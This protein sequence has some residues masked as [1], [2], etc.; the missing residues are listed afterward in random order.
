MHEPSRGELQKQ[1][2]NV[3][4]SHKL[5]PNNLVPGLARG[6]PLLGCQLIPEASYLHQGREH[7]RQT[8]D[9]CSKIEYPRYL[10]G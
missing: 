7:S 8:V 5:M 4:L 3:P 2:S 6:S 10:R 9:S 1:G